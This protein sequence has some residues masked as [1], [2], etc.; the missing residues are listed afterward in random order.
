MP[1][2]EQ[3]VLAV[4]AHLDRQLAGLEGMPAALLARDGFLFAILWQTKSRGCNAGMWRLDN[5]KLPAGSMP[6]EISHFQ[7]VLSSHV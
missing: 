3:E 5:L 4:L 1:W 7:I 2:T 6:S